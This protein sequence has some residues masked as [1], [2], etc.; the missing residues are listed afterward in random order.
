MY[1]KV[2]AEENVMLRSDNGGD[3]W[4]VINDNPRSTNNRPFYFQE[5]AVDSKDPNRVY[6]IY[7]PLSV[8]YDGA[9]AFDPTPMIPADETKGIHADFH[10]FWVNPNDPEHF[11]I[12]G[13]GGLGITYDHGKVGTFQRLFRS[14]SFIKLMLIMIDP[15]M[16]MAACRIMVIGLD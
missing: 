1:A 13:D 5:L 14:L 3:S 7:Q 9:K 11:I 12:G 2:E 10:S 15:I 6:N 8:S 16:F 4:Y